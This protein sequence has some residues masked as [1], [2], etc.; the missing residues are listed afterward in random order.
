MR[1]ILKELDKNLQKRG[2]A[3]PKKPALNQINTEILEIDSESMTLES[4]RRVKDI[5]KLFVSA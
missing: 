2:A 3:A 1:N 5:K 4:L